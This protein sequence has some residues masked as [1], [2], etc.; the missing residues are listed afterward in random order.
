[1]LTSP[2]S[3]MLRGLLLV[4]IQ[5]W[6]FSFTMVPRVGSYVQNVLKRTDFSV[7][8]NDLDE[9]AIGRMKILCSY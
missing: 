8:E 4:N 9:I 2:I 3:D 5:F 7:K 6:V 1:M